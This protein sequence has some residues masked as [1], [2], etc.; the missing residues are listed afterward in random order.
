MKKYSRQLTVSMLVANFALA[1]GCLS[2]LHEDETKSVSSEG[3]VYGD[4]QGLLI[5]HNKDLR[6]YSFSK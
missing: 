5:P 4:Q 6:D 2:G 3:T 1:V